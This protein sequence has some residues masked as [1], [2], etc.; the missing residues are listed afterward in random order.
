MSQNFVK[1]QNFQLE[2]LVDFEKCCKTRIYL[3][4]SEPIQPKTSNILPKFCQPTRGLLAEGRLLLLD[5][6]EKELVETQDSLERALVLAGRSDWGR[7]GGGG[8]LCWCRI[9]GRPKQIF[10]RAIFFSHFWRALRGVATGGAPVSRGSHLK[11]TKKGKILQ[12]IF[13]PICVLSKYNY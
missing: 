6:T 13:Y 2:N 7:G 10:L 5:A 1:F 12:L 4:K 3:Q 9:F 11:K 8:P